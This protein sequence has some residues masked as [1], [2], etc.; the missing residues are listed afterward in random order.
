MDSPCAVPFDSIV[1]WMLGHEKVSLLG[2][3]PMS[4]LS[5]RAAIELAAE[6]DFPPMLIASRNQ[7]DSDASGGGYVLCRTQRGLRTV[8]QETLRSSG[9]RGPVFLCRDHGGPWQ[10]DDEYRYALPAE[11]AM[12][13]AKHSYLEDLLNGFNL[14]HI[15]P[16]KDPGLPSPLPPALVIDRSIELIA[17][18]ER[19]RQA[20]GLPPVSYE[21]G[22]DEIS[23]WIL[24]PGSFRGFISDL[25]A[26]LEARG[27]PRPAF[28]VGQTGTLVRMDRNLGRTNLQAAGELAA[29][30]REFGILFKEHNADYLSGPCLDGHPEVGISASNVAPEF[31]LVETDALLD[32][33]AQEREACRTCGADAPG[34][35]RFA[36][37]LEQEV[38]RQHRWRKWLLPEQAEYDEARLLADRTVVTDLM[39]VC[40]HYAFPSEAVAQARSVLFANLVLLGVQ[41]DPASHL[42]GRIKDAMRRYVQAFRLEGLNARISA[43]PD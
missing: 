30:A 14:I 12:A 41:P 40:G 33:A 11:I 6:N 31:G 9:Y 21:V 24:D 1:H 8:V 13:L 34:E 3:G 39:R 38:L 16:T 35:S 32:L 17:F 22:T 7:I 28:I 25:V 26:G 36:E 42:V 10:R 43:V 4:E 23:G 29:I 5:I 15:D 20:R 37:V 2:I 18:I 27:L 19:E